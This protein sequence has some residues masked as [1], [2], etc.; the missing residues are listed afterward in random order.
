MDYRLINVKDCGYDFNS[1]NIAYINVH[2]TCKEVV[3]R[4]CYL[5]NDGE[6]PKLSLIVTKP[7]IAKVEAAWKEYNFPDLN[8]TK[9]GFDNDKE[10]EFDISFDGIFKSA[11][12]LDVFITLLRI[13]H[14]F[15]DLNTG[16]KYFNSWKESYSGL[17]E[18]MEFVINNVG[19]VGQIENLKILDKSADRNGLI[20]NRSEFLKN[21]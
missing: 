3:L 4:S 15:D 16:I 2:P 18:V 7:L 13:Y 1:E 10:I 12:W 17:K 9:T 11:A 8:L 6:V 19:S 20:F 21:E 14:K 5:N